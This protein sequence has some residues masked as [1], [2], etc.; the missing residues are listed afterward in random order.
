VAEGAAGKRNGEF[1]M[2]SKPNA[3]NVSVGA[4][5]DATPAKRPQRTTLEG[6]VVRVVPLDPIAHADTLFEGTR[7]KENEGLWLYLFE[8]PFATRAAFDSHLKQKASSEDPLFFAI[9]D[10]SSGDAVG[11]AAYMRIEPA[12]RVIEVGSILYT[13]RLQRT[14]GATEAMYLMARHVFEDLGYRR[15]EWKCNALNAPS[16]SAALRLGFTFEG[17]FRQHM[18]IKGRNRDTAWFSMLDS[19]WPK[20]KAA[21]ERWLNPSNFDA[22]GRQRISLSTLSSKVENGDF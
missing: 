19:E 9:L 13:A 18:I 5:V 3:E 4:R 20:R 15:Y 17:I 11:H 7:G 22:N 10:K 14:I 12:H 1:M 2:I 8:G 6:R 16:R 21:F